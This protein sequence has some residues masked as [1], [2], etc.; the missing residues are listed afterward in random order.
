MFDRRRQGAQGSGPPSPTS[1]R[2]PAAQSAAAAGFSFAKT[3]VVLQRQPQPAA[4]D[5]AYHRRRLRAADAVREA[6][7]RIRNS[8]RHGRLWSEESAQGD[9]VANATLGR[10]ET[11]AERE[12]RLR[13]L[14]NDLRD[15][16]V[17]LDS[18]PVPQSWFDLRVES[19]SEKL[20]SE[21]HG[22][23]PWEDVC[24]LYQH[25]Q[26]AMGRS[27]GAASQN[28]F[29]LLD[30][31][32]PARQIRPSAI[33][34]GI[35][36]GIYI[37]VPDPDTAPLVYWRLTGHEGWQDRGVIVDVW[38]DDVGYYYLNHGRKIYL[39]GRP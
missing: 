2:A 23:Q 1:A 32:V 19:A 5:P 16:L 17:Q 28:V 35:Q 39:P 15:L 22:K 36:T 27:L 38:H 6:I 8:L 33:S 18:G 10:T 25:R 4:E 7:D 14:A 29:Y 20:A 11:R 9:S 24:S 3:P 12:A 31:A 30:E 37:V 26:V 21:V 34:S 13:T